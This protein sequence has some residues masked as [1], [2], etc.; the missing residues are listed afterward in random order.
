MHVPRAVTST[1]AKASLGELLSSL[2]EQ[3]PV[4]ITRNG[5]KVAV[6]SP[7]AVEPPSVT[8]PTQLAHLA[9]LYAAG[10][11]A[12]REIAAQTPISFGELLAEL[13]RQGLEI[14]RV[15]PQRRPEQSALFETLLRRASRR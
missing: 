5:R 3:G 1:E 12:W 9:S 8:D 11:I 13:G 10:K 7:P 6:L 14:P 2:V 4:E 15:Q